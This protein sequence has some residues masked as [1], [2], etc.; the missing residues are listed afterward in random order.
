MT[1]CSWAQEVNQFSSLHL[2]VIFFK[3]G[4]N[5]MNSWDCWLPKKNLVSWRAAKWHYVFPTSQNCYWIL[6]CKFASTLQSYSLLYTWRKFKVVGI[7]TIVHGEGSWLQ[8]YESCQV[9]G[10][11]YESDIVRTIAYF[12]V[13]IDIYFFI[14][15]VPKCNVQVTTPYN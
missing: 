7:K 14:Q 3:S 2:G 8:N 15:D 4:W 10:Q 5:F 12:E 11:R 13:V 6:K 9:S 1:I